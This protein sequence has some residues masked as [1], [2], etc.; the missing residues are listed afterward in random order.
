[1]GLKE[2]ILFCNCY[3]NLEK[4]K[5]DSNISKYMFDYVCFIQDE[6]IEYLCGSYAN[7]KKKDK[8]ITYL[9]NNNPFELVSYLL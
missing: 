4:M 1:M 8:I 3:N 7:I 9:K 6:I 2:G 5:Y